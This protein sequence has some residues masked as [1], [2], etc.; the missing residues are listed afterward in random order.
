MFG[1]F[2]NCGR[3]KITSPLLHGLWP[4]LSINWHLM[5]IGVII[6]QFDANILWGSSQ[7][8]C[9]ISIVWSIYQISKWLS[10]FIE[11]LYAFFTLLDSIGGS[12]AKANLSGLFLLSFILNLQQMILLL[13][14]LDRSIILSH[15]LAL[16]SAI[17][18]RSHLWN[19]H[20]FSQLLLLSIWKRFEIYLVWRNFLISWIV[21]LRYRCLRSVQTW[22][23]FVLWNI[24]VHGVVQGD[25]ILLMN[26]LIFGIH[27]RI[28]LTFDEVWALLLLDR[29]FFI[30]W[31]LPL[32]FRSFSTRWLLSLW[33]YL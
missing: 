24:G 31:V 10:L 12:F 21:W 9:M 29:R 7:R 2:G 15:G 8:L 19:P 11:T 1:C 3:S 32:F 18:A 22:T 28:F 16:I 27:R 17:I 26:L 13:L 20:P 30:R 33:S 25:L 14:Q 6:L 4:L 5:K 23:L